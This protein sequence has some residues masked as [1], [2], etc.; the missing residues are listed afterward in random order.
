MRRTV[1]IFVTV[2]AFMQSDAANSQTDC[3][4][5]RQFPEVIQKADPEYSEEALNA[6]VKGAVVVTSEVGTDGRAHHIRVV[7]SLGYGLDEEAVATVAQ[8]RFKPAARDGAC[9]PAHVTI[10]VVFR[11]PRSHKR[12]PSGRQFGGVQKQALSAP[13]K[14][15]S[16]ATDVAGVTA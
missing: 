4:G 6:G 12:K 10:E 13:H 5:P 15:A 14:T 7:K 3:A 9:I 1:L 11:L 8:W 16:A 2:G